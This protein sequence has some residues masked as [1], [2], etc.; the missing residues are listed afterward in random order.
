MFRKDIFL[1]ERHA[2]KR[3]FFLVCPAWVIAR[4]CKSV[5][6]LVVGIIS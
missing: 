4:R 5:M 3:V 2:A 1:K 6:S